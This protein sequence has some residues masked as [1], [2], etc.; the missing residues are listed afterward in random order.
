MK[1]DVEEF[2]R[3]DGIQR[4]YFFDSS[5][6]LRLERVSASATHTWIWKTTAG[7]PFE[8]NGGAR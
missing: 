2:A 7:K 6:N 1:A 5:G 4:G 8:W 3:K